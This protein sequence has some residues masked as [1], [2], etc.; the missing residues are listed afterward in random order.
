M[1]GQCARVGTRRNLADT[2][3]SV[4]A[5]GRLNILHHFTPYPYKI[6][7]YDGTITRAARQGITYVKCPGKEDLDEMFFVYVPSI[8][9]TIISL[10]HHTRTHPKIRKWA[11]EAVPTTD[12]GWVTFRDDKDAVVS[13]YKTKKENGLYYRH[14][15]KRI[16]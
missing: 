4:S 11:Q 14:K 9:G 16:Y 10:E 2:S 3:A 5:T 8:D 1:I 12:T 15:Q 6:M 7:G 13:R